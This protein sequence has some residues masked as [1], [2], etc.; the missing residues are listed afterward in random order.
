MNAVLVA[1][2]EGYRVAREHRTEMEPRYGSQH[3]A[4]RDPRPQGI[5]AGCARRSHGRA[6]PDP[7][8][9]GVVRRGRGSRGAR[10]R[11]DDALHRHARRPSLGPHRALAGFR[12]PRL[13]L[14]YELR[15]PQGQGADRQSS[16]RDDLPLDGAR[17]A[18]AD[19]GTRGADDSGRERRLFSQSAE[20]LADRGLELASERGHP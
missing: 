18:G 9:R 3:G 15:E 8:V 7:A 12:R 1:A 4:T 11:G 16:C 5:R 19:R 10:A 2:I 14:L 17:A 13:L 6:R 20:Q